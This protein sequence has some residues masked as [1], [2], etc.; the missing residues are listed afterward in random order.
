MKEE[1]C[2]MASP[3]ALREVVDRNAHTHIQ[4]E[5]LA[6]LVSGYAGMDKEV[7]RSYIFWVAGTLVGV[8]LNMVN[9]KLI[10]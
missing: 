8:K 4:L 10:F 5:I 2:D 1:G 6:W 3:A 7:E 9:I